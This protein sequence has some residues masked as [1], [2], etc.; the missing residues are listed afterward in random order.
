M[1]PSAR[2]K[3]SVLS[4]GSH[5]SPLSEFQAAGPAT[6]KARRPYVLILCSAQQGDDDWW[7]EDAFIMSSCC[8]YEYISS[9]V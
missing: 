6:A 3:L 2:L 9:T 7:N 4:A 1:H 8:S 5:R